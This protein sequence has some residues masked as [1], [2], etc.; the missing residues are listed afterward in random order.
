MA[1]RVKLDHLLLD[2]RVT[3]TDLADRIGITIANLSVL[4]TNKA[5]AIR[6]STL[7][8]LCRELNCPPGELLEWTREELP[9]V[10]SGPGS[11]N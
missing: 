9:V 2:R 8:A 4:K 3:L 7:E 1:I 10:S 6:F 11:S 5:R